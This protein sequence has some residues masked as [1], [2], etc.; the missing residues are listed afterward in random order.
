MEPATPGSGQNTVIDL[1]KE[2]QKFSAGHFTIFNARERENLHGH[3]FRV[4]VQISGQVGPNG[5]MADYGRFKDWI[6]QLCREW[7]EVFLLPRHS[8]FLKLEEGQGQVRAWFDGEELVFLKRDVLVLPVTNTT[9]EELSRLFAARL[10]EKI[11]REKL[12][13]VSSLTVWISSG[14][15]QFASHLLEGME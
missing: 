4:R 12:S 9:L 11:Q 14:D 7:N 10:R 13:G 15:G 5:M 3:N 8:P 2:D 6:R 1:F